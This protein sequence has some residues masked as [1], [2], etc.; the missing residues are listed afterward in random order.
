MKVG[1]R[2]SREVEVNGFVMNVNMSLKIATS[3]GLENYVRVAV[4]TSNE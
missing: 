3:H 2:D 4:Q 1:S